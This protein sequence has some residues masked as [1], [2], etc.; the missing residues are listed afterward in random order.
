MEGDGTRWDEMEREWMDKTFGAM[1]TVCDRV[2]TGRLCIRLGYHF[3]QN[4]VEYR[5]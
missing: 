2:P 1:A 3:V 5:K 4:E